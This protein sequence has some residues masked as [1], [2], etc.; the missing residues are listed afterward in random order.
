MVP[1]KHNSSP[2]RDALCPYLRS[3]VASSLL[4]R[5]ATSQSAAQALSVLFSAPDAPNPNFASQSNV[6]TGQAPSSSSLDTIHTTSTQTAQNPPQ[7]IE[8]PI[9]QSSPE[10]Q[11]PHENSNPG[12]QYPIPAVA[13]AFQGTRDQEE[14][15]SQPNPFLQDV[16]MHQELGTELM[17]LQGLSMIGDSPLVHPCD[18]CLWFTDLVPKLQPEIPVPRNYSH[19]SGSQTTPP[20]NATMTTISH[21]LSDRDVNMSENPPANPRPIT[22]IQT[23]D[24]SPITNS[25]NIHR[26]MEGTSDDNGT[27]RPP[28]SGA[29]DAPLDI[30]NFMASSGLSSELTSLLLRGVGIAVQEGVKQ[31]VKEAIETMTTPSKATP[32]KKSPKRS[33]SHRNSEPMTHDGS[34][35][36]S[37]DGN[38]FISAR[39]PTGE[40]TDEEKSFHTIL[41]DYLKGKSLWNTHATKTADRCL[42][43]D[44]ENDNNDGPT[45]D[46]PVFDWS[47]KMS[48]MWNDQLLYHMAVNI[49]PKIRDTEDLTFPCQFKD[50]GFVKRVLITKL[51]RTRYK[52]Q[53]SIAPAHGD[54]ETTEQKQIRVEAERL[55]EEWANRRR[56]RRLNVSTLGILSWVASHPLVAAIY[57]M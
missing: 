53:N 12:A 36:S 56:T 34:S 37:A 31:G 54:P 15:Q 55:D 2:P 50:I 20:G 44:F 21:L 11:F 18:L 4:Q 30:G 7:A 16:N 43:N 10:A 5:R 17:P 6:S 39:K 28:T 40:K 52:Y 22:N 48:S 45:L 38:E 24:P 35:E 13:P 47:S 23:N 26:N 33:A 41:K 25:K 14:E 57:I 8:G 42:V 9:V 19:A 49:I 29:T 27:A 51:R 32:S 3:A 46:E 1:A